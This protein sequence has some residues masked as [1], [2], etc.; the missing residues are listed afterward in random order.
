MA[1]Y[2]NLRDSNRAASLHSQIV[3]IKDEHK[4]E[5]TGLEKRNAGDLEKL[6]DFQKT[7]TDRLSGIVRV[8]RLRADC[9]EQR[10]LKLNDELLTQRSLGNK[11]STALSALNSKAFREG[12]Q[13]VGT[14]RHCAKNGECLFQE[15]KAIAAASHNTDALHPLS[16]ASIP[17]P[18][19]LLS[20]EQRDLLRFRGRYSSHIREVGEACPKFLSNL[21]EDGCP[22]KTHESW[23]QVARKIEA[24]VGFLKDFADR[25]LTRI[26]SEAE[27]L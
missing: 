9:E 16:K 13:Y 12:L 24:H 4:T 10:A 23:Q 25:E 6:R 20:W 7:E 19:E 22:T 26:L 2:I 18:S 1:V 21:I 14:L 15:L 3:T 11:Q 5:I 27:V 17:E 8:E